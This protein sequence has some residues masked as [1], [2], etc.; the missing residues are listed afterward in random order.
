MILNQVYISKSL[1]A[2]N[3][4]KSRPIYLLGLGVIHLQI[5]SFYHLVNALTFTKFI[6]KTIIL[7][8]LTLV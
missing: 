8:K 2:F 7:I 3:H 4:V 6:I 5:K 1:Y